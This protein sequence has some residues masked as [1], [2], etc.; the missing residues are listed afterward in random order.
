VE[1]PR[2][3]AEHDRLAHHEGLA[4]AV[5]QTPEPVGMP[6]GI[7]Y[8]RQR[9]FTGRRNPAEAILPKFCRIAEAP[10]SCG[11]QPPTFDAQRGPGRPLAQTRRRCTSESSSPWVP[12]SLRPKPSL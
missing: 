4:F 3:A 9:D 1:Q 5:F 6:V 12:S 7:L 11:S 8:W 2:W 10:N